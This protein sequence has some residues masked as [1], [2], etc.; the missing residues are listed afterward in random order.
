MHDLATIKRLNAAASTPAGQIA[1]VEINHQYPVSWSFV[2]GLHNVV[3]G[4]QVRA[5]DCDLA[6]AREFGECV[7]H[8]AEC[9]GAFDS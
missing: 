5:F 4:E 6:A 8:A 7:R 2:G 1:R 9:A 3:Y